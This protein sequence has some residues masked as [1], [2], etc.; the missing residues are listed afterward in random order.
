MHFVLCALV[1]GATPATARTMRN[2]ASIWRAASNAMTEAPRLAGSIIDA[3]R[4]FRPASTLVK[5]CMPL[6][7]ALSISSCGGTPTITGSAM[8]SDPKSI[9]PRNPSSSGFFTTYFRT[10]HKPQSEMRAGRAGRQKPRTHREVSRYK[11]SPQEKKA[12]FAA[13]CRWEEKAPVTAHHH[14]TL[15]NRFRTSEFTL[16]KSACRLGR[17]ALSARRGRGLAAAIVHPVPPAHRL[18]LSRFGG[19]RVDQMDFFDA[20]LARQSVLLDRCNRPSETPRH[21]C[22]PCV[23][24]IAPPISAAPSLLASSREG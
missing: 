13:P 18:G 1:N 8:A 12:A 20:R 7:T 10:P 24:M 3:N 17:S 19:T 5:A 23:P 6:P 4:K 21:Q 9:R 22:H 14:L 16:C 11:A 15:R 2:L